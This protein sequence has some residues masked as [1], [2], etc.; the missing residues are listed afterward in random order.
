MFCAEKNTPGTDVRFCIEIIFQRRQIYFL[1]A[2]NK[3]EY[4][5]SVKYKLFILR[6]VIIIASFKINFLS[7]AFL[8]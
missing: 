4:T 8:L 1:S 5:A 3:G 7:A 2:E 6:F